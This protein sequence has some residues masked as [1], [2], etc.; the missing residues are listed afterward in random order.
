ML[1]RDLLVRQSEVLD[2]FNVIQGE[3]DSGVLGRRG[4][5]KAGLSLASRA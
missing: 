1:T 2:N 5:Y 3:F 4:I